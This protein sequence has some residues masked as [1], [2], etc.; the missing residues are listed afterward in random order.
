MTAVRDNQR[1]KIMTPNLIQAALAAGC[2]C[3]GVLVGS[4]FTRQSIAGREPREA[5]LRR[6]RRFL[7][8]LDSWN[9]AFKRASSLDRFSA[10][11]GANI[12]A[13]EGEVCRIRPD[14]KGD[15]RE[16]FNALVAAVS[17][18]TSL[19]LQAEPDADKKFILAIDELISFI[20]ES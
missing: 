13:F 1:Q 10:H 3:A 19:M 4:F 7:N 15:Q 9:F 17:Q 2:G 11:F 8:F 16:E 14:F 18:Y 20:K 5:L 12:S 6:H